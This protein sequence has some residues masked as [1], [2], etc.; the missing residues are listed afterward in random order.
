MAQEKQ[1]VLKTV[2]LCKPGK[3]GVVGLLKAGF[4]SAQLQKALS[5]NG[6]GGI[7]VGF[8]H[9]AE[10]FQQIV[11]AL[12]GDLQTGGKD[13]VADT[14]FIPPP[15]FVE[16]LPQGFPTQVVF[17]LGGQELHAG[18][19]PVGAA[20]NVTGQGKGLGLQLAPEGI[21]AL[22]IQDVVPANQVPETV[23]ALD[24]VGHTLGVVPGI[25]TAQ[26]LDADTGFLQ[27]PR[28][29][30]GVHH[31]QGM[32]VLGAPDVD[33]IGLKIPQLPGKQI[34]QAGVIG[35]GHGLLK[36]N[37]GKP[38]VNG[39]GGRCIAPAENADFRAGIPAQAGQNM[40]HPQ[41]AAA[42]IPHRLT[43][44]AGDYVTQPKQA[45]G[46]SSFSFFPAYP[47]SFWPGP[48]CFGFSE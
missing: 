44:G 48:D 24:A 9:L 25:D 11:V 28:I 16:G 46:F 6:Q 5:G 17:C 14:G 19:V 8:Q 32:A 30:A 37:V 42:R 7:R 40:V 20:Q 3:I 12:Q 39:A 31:G 29:P 1:L 13:P 2:L 43:D 33:R 15:P 35:I 23:A 36:H 26:A 18:P 41:S 4:L 22:L 27:E 21:F 47:G 38:I 34:F 45:H 10:G